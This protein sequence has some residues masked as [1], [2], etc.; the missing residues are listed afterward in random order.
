[1]NKDL[2]RNYLC[3]KKLVDFIFSPLVLAGFDARPRR[4]LHN[5]QIEGLDD[6]DLNAFF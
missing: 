6:F 4:S 1:M 3:N 2:F 5:I